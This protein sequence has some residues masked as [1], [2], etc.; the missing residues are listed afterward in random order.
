[1]QREQRASGRKIKRKQNRGIMK[2]NKKETKRKYKGKKESKF[3]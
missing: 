2:E 1:M 3:I